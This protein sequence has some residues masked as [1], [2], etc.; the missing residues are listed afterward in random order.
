MSWPE[1]IFPLPSAVN[2]PVTVSK[3]T[4]PVGEEYDPPEASNAYAPAK[5]LFVNTEEPLEV[6]D[7]PV[8]PLE[9]DVGTDAP[10][11]DWV[12]A[13]DGLPLHP[14]MNTNPNTNNMALRRHF[15]EKARHRKD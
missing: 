15:W 12:V 1:V 13:F 10:L 4:I 3:A 7:D 6:P 5:L 8:V 11:D 2:V 9:G 14:T